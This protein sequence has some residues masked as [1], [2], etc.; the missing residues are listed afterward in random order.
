[1][2]SVVIPAIDEAEA[3]AAL[4]ADLNAQQG[5]AKEIIVADG[6]SRD[7]TCAVARRGGAQVVESAP[8]RAAQMNAGAAR[9]RG[10]WLCFVHA[11]SG[12]THPRQLALAI[13]CLEAA[14]RNRVAGH[15]ALRFVR[16]GR[17]RRFLY[18]YMQAKS[19]TN[20][21]Y[22]INGDQ[23]LILRATFFADLGGFDTRL[24]FLEDQRMAATIERA[25][26]VWRLCPHR[27]A[28]SARR[29]ETEGE[30]ARYLLMALIMAMHIAQV[31]VFFERAPDVYARQRDTGRLA[32]MPYFRLLRALWRD[33]GAM[34]GLRV[35][36]RIA[37]VAL[38]Q[39][40]QPF[41]AV[42]VL[43]ET[44]AGTRRRHAMRLHDR[45][46]VPWI[47]HRLGQALLMVVLLG[48]V[49][50]PLQLWC[51]LRENRPVAGR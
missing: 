44:L 39:S 38:G 23:G 18:R 14:H 31:G 43:L 42:D 48:T 36:W 46:M 41:F 4:L 11:D 51:R 2:L 9:A 16:R 22:T 13:A 6:G 27:L 25:G 7:E 1:M 35:S 32:L 34:A 47:Q 17:G 37:G 26:G 3:L 49:F 40:W 33:C 15:F 45:W 8:G 29:F 12:F 21:R 5:I 28:T 50:G 19:E 30:R 24:P 10:T 20:R